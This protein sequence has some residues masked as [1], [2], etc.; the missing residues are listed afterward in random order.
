MVVAGWF[1]RCG[2]ALS[3]SRVS[4]ACLGD[5][6]H[7]CSLRMMLAAPVAGRLCA[8]ACRVCGLALVGLAHSLAEQ[9]SVLIV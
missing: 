9:Y 4:G 7:P 6:G 3:G 1:V 8:L 2:E 5:W